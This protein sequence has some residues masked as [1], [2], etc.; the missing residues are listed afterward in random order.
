MLSDERKKALGR[1]GM[2]ALD[3]ALVDLGYPPVRENPHVRTGHT[4]VF[5]LTTAVVEKPGCAPLEFQFGPELDVWVGPF[6][7]VVM[8][9][10]TEAT[11]DEVRSLIAQVLRSEVT[12]RPRWMSVELVLRVPGSEPWRRLRSFGG[13]RDLGLHPTSFAPYAP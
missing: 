11:R 7:E 2:E 13:S 4:E 3:G 5:G 8:Y 9:E 10:L 12:W 6:S 1:L